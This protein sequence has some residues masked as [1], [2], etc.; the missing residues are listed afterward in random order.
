[1]A[2]DAIQAMAN[3]DQLQRVFSVRTG[4]LE[5][6]QHPAFYAID[7]RRAALIGEKHRGDTRPSGT[8]LRKAEFWIAR[9]AMPR[10]T[11]V[12]GFYSVDSW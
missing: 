5:P 9:F 11:S 2:A 3:L 12:R 8:F 6:E 4:G 7:D 1:M 10:I